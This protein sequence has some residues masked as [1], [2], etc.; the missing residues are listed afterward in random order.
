MF[1]TYE[2]NQ[3]EK[4]KEHR[5]IICDALHRLDAFLDESWIDEDQW[6]KAWVQLCRAD[7]EIQ[8]LKRVVL[9]VR[10]RRLQVIDTQQLEREQ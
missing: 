5:F 2:K 8:M 4:I 6:G 9:R 7:A 1:D 10:S 3:F